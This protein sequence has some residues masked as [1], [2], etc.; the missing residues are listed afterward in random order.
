MVHPGPCVR[1]IMCEMTYH[2][3]APNPPSP[4]WFPTLLAGKGSVR[5][6]A[7]SI[8]RTES[9]SPVYVVSPTV[10]DGRSVDRMGARFMFESRRIESSARMRSGLYNQIQE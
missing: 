8:M 10:R 9:V 4:R 3:M 6:A 5:L 2:S 7:W 1:V